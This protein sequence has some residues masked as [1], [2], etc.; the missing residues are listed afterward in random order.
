VLIR[1]PLH[2]FG[3][4]FDDDNARLASALLHHVAVG[5][6]ADGARAYRQLAAA[7]L[8]RVDGRAGIVGDA[9]QDWLLDRLLDDA[10]PISRRLERA[11]VEGLGGSIREYALRELGLVRQALLLDWSE[12]REAL[13][14]EDLGP[15]WRDVAA[16]GR[17]PE[18]RRRAKEAALLARDAE[19]L[20]RALAAWWRRGLGAFGRHVAFRW[21][22]GALAGVARPDPIR[23][24]GLVGYEREQLP[25]V[26]NTRQFVRG[27]PANDV[28]LAGARGTG[29]SSTVKALLNEFAGEG[30]RHIEAP[31][32]V[33]GELPAIVASVASRPER[34]I[35]FVDDLSFDESEGEYKALK[36]L[37][38]GAT[39]ERPPNVVVYATSNRRNLI[40]ETWAERALGPDDVSPRERLEEKLS[41]ADRFGVRA[42]FPPPDQAQY[43][44]MVV[45]HARAHR[46]DLPD[47][48]LKQR[49]IR[50][51]LA[52]SGRSGRVA[53]QFVVSLLGEAAAPAR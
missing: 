49:A 9:W 39:S 21:V 52:H 43:L 42:S 35:V 13:E 3:G 23:L 50:W 29:K 15:G 51:E 18:D 12:V 46:I 7:L 2:Y 40:V 27:L 28:L 30:L 33:L 6:D 41:L 8:A 16:G 14:E 24:A 26:E 10:N 1:E 20:L 48:E 11:E 22:D 17:G 37:L 25:V 47:E 4:V 5:T 32:R 19:G 53:K 45:S 31:K 36:A 34:F 38:D 44:A